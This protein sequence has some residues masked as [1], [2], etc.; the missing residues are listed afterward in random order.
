MKNLNILK[1]CFLFISATFLFSGCQTANLNSISRS[2]SF[3]AG[4]KAIHLDAK[5]RVL[6]TKKSMVGINRIEEIACAEPS[7]DA[8]SAYASSF[9]MGVAVP[10][11]ISA[12]VAQA[13]SESSASIGLRTQS[14]QLLRDMLYRVCEAS[15]NKHLEPDMVATLHER[16][17]NITVGLLAI[18]QLTGATVARQVILTGASEASSSSSL[19]EVEGRLEVAKTRE[20]S[21]NEDLKVAKAN[22]SKLN[23]E[24]TAAQ[25]ASSS[26]QAE[27]NEL[28][29]KLETAKN[30][31][32]E[33]E[34][35]AKRAKE[36][37]ETIEKMAN[38][39]QTQAQAQAESGGTFSSVVSRGSLTPEVV[40]QVTQSVENI[41]STIVNKDHVVDTCLTLVA[42]AQRARSSKSVEASKTDLDEAT[43]EFC[44]N[45]LFNKNRELIIMN[46]MLS[47]Q[48]H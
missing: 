36:T 23:G 5:Q 48:G 14:I 27:I 11:Q 3:G 40:N 22:E 20:K 2:T 16:Y 17:Q 47:K 28:K 4:G 29:A 37:R 18:E 12:S 13:M 9:G 44:R 19:L 34:E 35:S 30:V 38:N 43:S 26:D 32:K 25:D 1:S 15:Y 39:V 42:Q 31:T 7:P 46:P 6:L 10:N 33:A 41:V 8:L 45:I 24:L 21:A